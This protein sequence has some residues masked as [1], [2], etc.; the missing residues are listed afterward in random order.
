MCKLYIAQ[1]SPGV[2]NFGENDLFDNKIVRD[3][4]Y[5]LSSL[6]ILQALLQAAEPDDPQDA[7]VARQYK[8]QPELYKKTAQHWACVYAGGT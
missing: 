1:N 3:I 7:V 2:N 8:E 5:M 6:I 4:I